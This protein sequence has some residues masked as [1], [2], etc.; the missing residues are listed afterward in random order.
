MFFCYRIG[1]KLPGEEG[2]TEADIVIPVAGKML[3]RS[4]DQ[5]FRKEV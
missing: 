4:A 1:D 5:Q 3:S 2:K